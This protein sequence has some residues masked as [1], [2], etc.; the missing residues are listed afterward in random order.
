[1]RAMAP[2]MSYTADEIWQMLPPLQ[3]RTA[4]VHLSLFWKRDEVLGGST[5]RSRSCH[6]G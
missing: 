5:R 3:A 1:M 2:L 6:P 4:S